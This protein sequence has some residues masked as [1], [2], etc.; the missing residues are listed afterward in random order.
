MKIWID[1]DEGRDLCIFQ[2][3]WGFINIEAQ[4]I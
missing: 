1:R 3:S 2:V 4:S